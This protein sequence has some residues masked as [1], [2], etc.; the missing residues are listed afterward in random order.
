MRPLPQQTAR[1]PPG[2][3]SQLIGSN[4]RRLTSGASLAGRVPSVARFE[5][6]PPSASRADR[7]F[8]F[9]EA[10]TTSSTQAIT[11]VAAK[12]AVMIDNLTQAINA[13]PELSQ[14]DRVHPAF[15]SSTRRPRTRSS[16]AGGSAP[17]TCSNCRMTYLPSAVPPASP[18]PRGWVC[19]G[20]EQ[21]L[22]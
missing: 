13:D 9:M 3:R 5:Q 18:A 8:P 21:T 11:M 15:G 12:R 20:C 7:R 1:R 16:A 17:I 2:H 4:G 10:P 22:G 6:Q 19:D 14:D